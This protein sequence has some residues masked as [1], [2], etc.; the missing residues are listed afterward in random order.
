MGS[1]FLTLTHTN[2]T[3]PEIPEGW[4]IS[5]VSREKLKSMGRYKYQSHWLDSGGSISGYGDSVSE[6]IKQ[7][8]E[9]E[10]TLKGLSGKSQAA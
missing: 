6:C 7:I 5:V 4:S 2:Q 8:K 3:I 9:L 10:T 1:S